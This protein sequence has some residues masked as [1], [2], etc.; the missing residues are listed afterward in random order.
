MV[1][2]I[3]NRDRTSSD[4]DSIFKCQDIAIAKMV[5]QFSEL[6]DLLLLALK[7]NMFDFDTL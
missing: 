7:K 1:Q 6:S 2:T 3:S 4:D 5:W